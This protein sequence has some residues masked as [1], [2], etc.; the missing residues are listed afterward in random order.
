[1]SKV[2]YKPG[3]FLADEYIALKA[4]QAELAKREKALKEAL[5]KLGKP[6]VEGQYGRVSISRCEGRFSYDSKMLERAFPSDS[7]A[8]CMK[9]S[10]PSIRFLVSARKA[11]AKVAA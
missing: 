7:L 1:M 5:L 4:Q 2:S 6:V 8:M 9:Q 11:D 10:A 3:D